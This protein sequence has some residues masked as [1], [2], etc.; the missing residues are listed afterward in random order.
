MIYVKEYMALRS[1]FYFWC[2]IS[3][4][5]LTLGLFG[6]CV[7]K[8]LGSPLGW[9]GRISQILWA[10]FAF[11]SLK[12]IYDKATKKGSPF[13]D[14]AADLF[15]DSRDTTLFVKKPADLKIWSH[16]ARRGS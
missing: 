4:Y 16:L 12:E 2:A 1:N 5:M 3:T 6:S 15:S 7:A 13:M 9:V 11:F 10:V 14:V 8:D